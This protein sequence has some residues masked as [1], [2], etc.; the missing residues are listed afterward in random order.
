[1]PGKDSVWPKGLGEKKPA[2]E[3]SVCQNSGAKLSK[4]K[5]VLEI[6]MVWMTRRFAVLGM[7]AMVSA[8]GD[9]REDRPGRGNRGGNNPDLHV[10][11]TP[12]L[13]R[14]INHHADMNGVPRALVHK[15]IIR[16]SH[17]RPEAHNGPYFGL[18]QILPETARGMGY[19]G[20][21]YGLLDA[22]TNLTYGVKYLRGAWLLSNGSFDT[23]EKWYARGYYYE[24]KRRGMLVETGLRS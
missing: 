12:E 14:L 22:D 19:R 24:A 15:I 4:P 13:R 16:E 2:R 7:V 3:S 8:C 17:H 20:T 23:A 10:N 11:E 6:Y 21:D 9:A 1:L 18:M 5:E